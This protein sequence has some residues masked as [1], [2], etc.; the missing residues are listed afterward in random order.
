MASGHLTSNCPPFRGV[1]KFE[2]LWDQSFQ[3]ALV[4]NCP[5]S[6]SGWSVGLIYLVPFSVR[7]KELGKNG[8]QLWENHIL[9]AWGEHGAC[10][11][12]WCIEGSAITPKPS[13]LIRGPNGSP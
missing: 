3:T 11:R 10:W 12:S 9:R 8:P 5:L 4:G 1:S 13:V 7:I 2:M 6:S